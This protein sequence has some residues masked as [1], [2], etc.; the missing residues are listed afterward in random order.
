MMVDIYLLMLKKIMD[1]FLSDAQNV[2]TQLL[3]NHLLQDQSKYVIL[4]IFDIQIKIV[5]RNSR[6][7]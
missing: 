1:F 6:N 7:K 3:I 5:T 4:V 2:L